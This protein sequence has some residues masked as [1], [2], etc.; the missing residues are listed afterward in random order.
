M[1]KK[2]NYNDNKR[3]NDVLLSAEGVSVHLC[4]LFICKEVYVKKPHKNPLC[5]RN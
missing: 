3:N 1:K 2:E 5:H 4:I